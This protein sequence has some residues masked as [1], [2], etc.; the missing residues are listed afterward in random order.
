MGSTGRRR[1]AWPSILSVALAIVAPVLFFHR[2]KQK[3]LQVLVSGSSEITA[4]TS[5]TKTRRTSSQCVGRNDIFPGN[6]T[7]LFTNVLLR[8]NLNS[9]EWKFSAI[10]AKENVRAS[11]EERVP[12]VSSEP[13]YNHN[14]WALGSVFRLNT[15]SSEIETGSDR[16]Y[17]THGLSPP[18]AIREDI[19][20]ASNS[21]GA[22]RISGMS[23]T[24]VE[25][26]GKLL[27]VTEAATLIAEK[28]GM[29]LT[30]I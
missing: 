18:K 12:P 28:H 19:A 8:R 14:R 26:K 13:L 7:C 4:K 20:D 2:D 15:E 10:A 16:M 25:S 23:L 21:F 29:N 3:Y 1:R 27:G 9:G 24:I 17:Q 5:K 22:K 30:V 6:R 11:N